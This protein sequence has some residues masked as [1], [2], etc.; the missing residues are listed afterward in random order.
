M[1]LVVLADDELYRDLLVTAVGQRSRLRIVGVFAAAEQA[2][3]QAPACQPD[4]A[5]I[6]ITPGSNALGVHLGMRLRNQLPRLGVC[7]LCDAAESGVPRLSYHTDPGWSHLHK[8]AVNN[9]LLLE[10]AVL[11]AAAGL[12]VLDPALSPYQSQAPRL[13]PRQLDVLRLIAQG[14]S[15]EAIAARLGLAEKT[16]ANYINVVYHKLSIDSASPAVQPRVQAALYYLR[17]LEG[18]G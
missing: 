12:V 1:R 5:L 2:L 7:L 18:N 13:A 17:E 14:Y 3:Q 4:V 16:V 8:G 15:N 11:A 10:Q 6:G 9:P